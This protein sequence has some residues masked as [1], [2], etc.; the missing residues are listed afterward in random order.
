MGPSDK[1]LSNIIHGSKP[2]FSIKSLHLYYIKISPTVLLFPH[3]AK[4]VFSFYLAQCGVFIAI[5]VTA[6]MVLE[7]FPMLKDS[8]DLWEDYVLIN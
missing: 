4:I 8:N 1:S 3:I 5:L 6:A 2:F 7:R